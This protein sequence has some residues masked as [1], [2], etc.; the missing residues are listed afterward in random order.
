MKAL[1]KIISVYILASNETSSCIRYLR[2]DFVPKNPSTLVVEVS[3]LFR[4]ISNES[5]FMKL[6]SEIR[7]NE[8]GRK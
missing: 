5:I 6:R 4:V 7:R 8:S 3:G 2:S 1:G